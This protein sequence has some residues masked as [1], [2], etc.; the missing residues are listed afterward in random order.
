MKHVYSIKKLE[1]SKFPVMFYSSEIKA[2]NSAKV[3]LFVLSK[4]EKPQVDVLR[5]GDLQ[6]LSLVVEG[7]SHN[8]IIQRHLVH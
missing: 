1:N 3:S 6:Y 7:V 2:F 8:I 4:E 5:V